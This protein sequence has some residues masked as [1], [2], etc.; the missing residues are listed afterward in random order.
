MKSLLDPVLA[1]MRREHPQYGWGDAGGGYFVINNMRIIASNG[2]GWD[3]VSVSLP[4][5]CPTWG[6]MSKIKRLFFA[7][8]ECVMQLHPPESN[9]VNQHEFCLHLWKPHAG[10]IPVPPMYMV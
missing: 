5:R 6:E 7:D 8:D 2:D 3:H 1:K 4:D 9:Y 10:T